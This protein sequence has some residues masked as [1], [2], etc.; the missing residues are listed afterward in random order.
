M[1]QPI[2]IPSSGWKNYTLLNFS[3]V[4]RWLIISDFLLLGGF[5]LIGPIFA[6]FITNNVTGANLQTAGI[7]ASIYLLTKSL[8]QIPVA[9]LLDKIKGEIDDFWALFLGMFMM[10]IIPLA[11]IFAS[12]PGWLYLIQFIYGLAAAFVF[13]AYMAIFTR[14]VDKDKEGLAW[15]TYF[16]FTDLGAAGAGAIGGTLAQY[17]GFQSL[18]IV[19]SGFSLLSTLCLLAIKSHLRHHLRHE[20][21]NEKL[22]IKKTAN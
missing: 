19:V 10:S 21:I 14:H 11:Y 3:P 20:I 15:G 12:T 6:I 2:N 7:A 22:T 16:T 13:P 1:E 4:V 5:G 17:I 18:F 9:S 8:G